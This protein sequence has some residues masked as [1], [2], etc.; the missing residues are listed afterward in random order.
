MGDLERQNKI[1]K[2]SLDLEN[3]LNKIK[4][5]MISNI[6]K[7]LD[8]IKNKRYILQFLEL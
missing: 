4:E 1:N 7:K 2:L 3:N 8:Q 5:E 6:N